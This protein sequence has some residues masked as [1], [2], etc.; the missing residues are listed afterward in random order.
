MGLSVPKVK[1]VNENLKETPLLHK[2]NSI[3]LGQILDK[4]HSLACTLRL[5]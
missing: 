5:L 1:N 3:F 4:S 2:K